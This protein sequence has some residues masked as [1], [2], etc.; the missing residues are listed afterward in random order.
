[1]PDQARGL[2]VG[3]LSPMRLPFVVTEWHANAMR[4][5]ALRDRSVD[6]DAKADAHY[7][8]VAAECALCS[9]SRHAA[10]IVD[11]RRSWSKLEVD[12]MAHAAAHLAH[13][14]LRV[15]SL[16]SRQER[17]AEDACIARARRQGMQ[18]SGLRAL[19]RHAL[20]RLRRSALY[21]A[22][23]GRRCTGLLNRASGAWRSEAQ[24]HRRRR[25]G[26]LTAQSHWRKGSMRRWRHR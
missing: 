18:R 6:F 9:L 12:A 15:W 21:T 22:A 10:L 23:A 17:A 16:R 25:D 3:Y 14:C 8:R 19:T 7:A 24:R 2:S 1:M 13:R 5:A 26:D 20:R 4:L 11:Q